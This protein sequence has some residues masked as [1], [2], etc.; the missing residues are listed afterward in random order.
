MPS[1]CCLLLLALTKLMHPHSTPAIPQRRTHGSVLFTRGETQA[2]CVT[3]LGSKSDALKASSIRDE[4]DKEGERFY[5]QYFFPPS[6]VGETGRLGGAGAWGNVWGRV[7]ATG[8]VRWRE[9]G[10][11]FY[12]HREA[13]QRALGYRAT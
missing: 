7:W 6:S 1:S 4:D 8:F 11:R 5:L 13:A 9:E 3:T 10:V 2:L 12:L